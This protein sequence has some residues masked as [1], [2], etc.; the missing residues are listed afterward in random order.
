MKTNVF[1]LFILLFN[2]QAILSQSE[3]TQFSIGFDISPKLLYRTA[4]VDKDILEGGDYSK[5]IFYNQ[6]INNEK[7]IFGYSIGIPFTWHKN[8]KTSIETGLYYS[9]RGFGW[10]DDWSLYSNKNS[11]GKVVHHFID[12]PFLI[13]YSL[14]QGSRIRFYFKGGPNLNIIIKSVE[15]IEYGSVGSQKN[16]YDYNYL[17]DREY[18]RF[19]LSAAIAI[20]TSISISDRFEIRIEPILNYSLNAI[21]QKGDITRRF[22]EFGIRTGVILRI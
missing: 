10:Y 9:Q 6:L 8:L 20:G 13:N 22:R 17:K 19:N 5:I 15:F 14:Y 3:L 1:L 4:Q 21:P 16:V 11:N 2:F 7:P 18:R 12:V